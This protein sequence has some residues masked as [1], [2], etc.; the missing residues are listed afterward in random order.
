MVYRDSLL[1]NVI[2]L[3]DPGILGGW[4]TLVKRKALLAAGHSADDHVMGFTPLHDA[5]Q[6]L[7]AVRESQN[8]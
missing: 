5:A 1:T 7:G 3:V 8:S 2:I 4:W 6:L